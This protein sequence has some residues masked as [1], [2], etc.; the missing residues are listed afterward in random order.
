MTPQQLNQL[1]NLGEQDI[2]RS[3]Q[4][5]PGISAS[6]ESSSGMYIRGGTPDQNLIVYD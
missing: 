4:L 5:M 3:F 6:N 2:M 1:P